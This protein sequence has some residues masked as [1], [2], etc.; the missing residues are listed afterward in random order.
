M[1]EQEAAFSYLGRG[2]Q[3]AALRYLSAKQE[4]A[5]M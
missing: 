4:V 1:G 2:K 3:E 5:F